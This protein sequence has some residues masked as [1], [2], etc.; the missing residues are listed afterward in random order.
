M[1]PIIALLLSVVAIMGVTMFWNTQ[2]VEQE[3]QTVYATGVLFG[4]MEA[5]HQ[6]SSDPDQRAHYLQVGAENALY[7][8]RVENGKFKSPDEK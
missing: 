2:T 1:K 6:T 4:M 5:Y 8:W 7:G 3:K